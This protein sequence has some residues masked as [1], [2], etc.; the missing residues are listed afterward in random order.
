MRKTTTVYYWG[1]EDSDSI[2]NDIHHH[3][4]DGWYVHQIAPRRAAK[5]VGDV[6]I[7]ESDMFVVYA[8]DDS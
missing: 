1:T 2:M 5:S 6:S 4:R 7:T 3:E 8:R